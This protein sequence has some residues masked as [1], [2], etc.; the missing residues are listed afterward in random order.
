MTTDYFHPESNLSQ[1]SSPM[2]IRKDQLTNFMLSHVFHVLRVC[3]LYSANQALM[4][5][6]I[7]QP[8]LKSGFFW[9]YDYQITQCK[10]KVESLWLGIMWSMC[11]NMSSTCVI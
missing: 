7:Q 10:V 4:I 11:S 5:S 8:Q 3:I 6:V 9:I 1:I 2:T